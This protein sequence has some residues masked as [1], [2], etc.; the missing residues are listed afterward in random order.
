MTLGNMT[1]SIN[2]NNKCNSK[3]NMGN[4]PEIGKVKIKILNQR[5]KFV[6][7]T[8]QKLLINKKI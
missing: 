1:L 5:S 8:K 4:Q 6:T 7:E 2:V 3:C